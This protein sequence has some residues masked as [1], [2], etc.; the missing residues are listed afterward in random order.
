MAAA[1]SAPQ[2]LSEP[3]RRIPLPLSQLVEDTRISIPNHLLDSKI[4]T[5]LKSNGLI[6]ADP[7]EI[8]FSGFKLGKDYLKSLKLINISSEVINIHIIPTQTKPFQTIYTKKYR[9]VPGLSYTLNVQFHP[10]EWRYFYDC[11]RVHC[12]GDENI[13]IPVHAYPIIDDLCFPPRIDL[14]ATPLGQSVSRTIPLRCSCPVDFEFQVDIIE[15]HKAFSIHP[16]TGVI[17]A[18]GEVKITVTFSPF[19][20]E[21]CQ[22]TIQL[23]ISQFNTKPHLC[24]IT[25]SSAPHL[26]SS[27]M[28]KGFGYDLEVSKGPSPASKRFLRNKANYRSTKEAD[29]SKTLRAHVEVKPAL[30]LLEDVCSPG[31]VA[32]MLI[33]D[34]NKFSSQDLR[35]AMSC[36]SMAG[37]QNR[38][39]KEAHFLKKIQQNMREERDRRHK[40][41]VHLG[42]DPVPEQMRRTILEER[43]IAL[44]EYMVKKGGLWQDEE[45]T[46]GPPKLFSQRVLCEVG[47]VPDEVPSFEF[48]PSC[49]KEL[50]DRAR[51]M[52]QQA[53]RKVV[54]R[55]RMNARLTSLKKLAESMKDSPSAQQVDEE[56]QTCTLKVSPDKVFP[57]SFPVFSSEANP[58]ALRNLTAV[59]VDPID[60]TVTA[61]I[62]FFKLQVPQH[63]KQRGYRP[64][65]AWEAYDAFIPLPPDTLL[66]TAVSDSENEEENVETRNLSFSIPE[67]LLKPFP[68]HPLRIFNPAP[69]LRAYKPTPKY[70]ETDLEYH[71]CPLPRYPVPENNTCGIKTQT[72]STQKRFLD[73]KEMI[74]GVMTWKNFDSITLKHLSKQPA[75]T[76]SWALR[77][78]VDYNTEILPLTAPPL[79][80]SG[81]PDDLV[82]LMDKTSEESGIQLTPEMIKAEFLSPEVPFSTNN[83]MSGV[84]D[85]CQREREVEGTYMPE[86]NQM[87]KRV[88]SRLKQLGLSDTTF[89][90]AGEYQ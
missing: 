7:P 14:P 48:H 58:L 76:S 9:L 90:S 82:M 55:C 11:I 40:W 41:Q 81:F 31:G 65:S 89:H 5:K 13:L 80:L 39:L 60:V 57:S 77:R 86:F 6:E 38:Q 64:I 53:A 8:H 87:G 51:R 27:L 10:D 25:G 79:P 18:N 23:V 2:M 54:I 16:L 50:K 26:A 69:G 45:F 19:Q 59:P 29:K 20:Y 44:R 52:F 12:K 63:Y 85:R 62:P 70:L 88:M 71:L 21:T 75:L 83:L 34:G 24:T 36:G 35:D 47:Q 17:P 78:S 42:N 68:A 37:L 22:I 32:K 46:A 61:H 15:T 84:T 30:Q 28:E 49:P 74:K 67:A 72:P 73:H 33:K 4:Y 3:L 66:Y 43:E 56:K 1:L